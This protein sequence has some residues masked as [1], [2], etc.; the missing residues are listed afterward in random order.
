MD[1]FFEKKDGTDLNKESAENTEAT[2]GNENSG[3]T[4]RAEEPKPQNTSE[5]NNP[6]NPQGQY[7][8][9]G[10][11][12]YG[13]TDFGGDNTAPQNRINYSDIVPVGDYKPMSRGL[14]VFALI[15]AA[16]ILLTGVSVTGYF[17][18]RN[19]VSSG[20]RKNVTVNLAAKP[21]DSDEMTAAQVYEKVNSSIVGITVYNSAGNG[22]QA[23]GVFYSNDGYIVTNDHIYS[24]VGA[25]KFKVY[26]SDGKEHDAKYVA[27]DQVSDL[28]VLKI[29]G[30]GF[31]AAE[32]GNSEEIVYG[33]N[34]VAVGRPSDATQASSI[35]KGIIS[36]TGRRVKT[37][38]NY[39][40]K[41]IQTD[42]A[43]NPGSSGGA[44]VNMYGQVIGIT[45]SKLAGVSYDAV[46]YAI[47]TKTLKRI[48]E[49]LIKNGKVVSRAK[50]GITYTAINSVMAEINGYDSV[51]LYVASV[52][53]DSDLYG[54]VTEGDIITHINGI[55]VTSDDVVLDIIEES[56][57]GDKISVT[58][59][60]KK[61]NETTLEAVLKANTG[62][63]S[64]SSEITL[65]NNSDNSNSSGGTFNFPFGE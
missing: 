55:K 40:A 54:K 62:E 23:S 3:E 35:T 16:V 58:L 31:T 17:L 9:Y 4:G 64:Y 42:S 21:A 29:D 13:Y 5:N 19:S 52:A 46:G 7:S 20:T 37:T 56:S 47:P 22:S 18:G 24:E 41:L 53:E 43:I 30:S 36:S 12:N 57:A 34:V 32:F 14:K 27:G 49:E 11:Q 50:L 38:S 26:T 51:G 25:A 8:P 44:L 28:A 65:P 48:C 10:S 1:D 60:T 59:L 63:S 2:A 39:S 45:S 33:E 6:Y 61:G 15:M